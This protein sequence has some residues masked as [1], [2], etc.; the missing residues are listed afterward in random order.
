VL[1]GG[2]VY[3]T[4]L[5]ESTTGIFDLNTRM[6]S[7]GY[8]YCFEPF[9]TLPGMAIFDIPP[10]SDVIVTVT[11]SATSGNV[12]CGAMGLGTYVYLGAVIVTS[13]TNDGLNFSTIDRDVFGNA[14]LIPRRTVPKTE[15][16]L[17]VSSDRIDRIKAVRIKLNAVPALWTGI[18]DNTSPWFDALTIMGIYTQFKIGAVTEARA[19][20]NLSLEEI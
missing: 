5:S 17:K 14:N 1:G 13:A 12:K 10:F 2:T 16:T 15:Q 18:D 6:V 11:I 9:S 4:A 3:P 7:D 19:E 8:D 20:V